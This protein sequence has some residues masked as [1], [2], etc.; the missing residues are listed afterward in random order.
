MTQKFPF[1]FF[2][3][4]KKCNENLILGNFFYFL[5][6]PAVAYGAVLGN[7][8]GIHTPTPSPSIN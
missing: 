3:S 8:L 4:G 6:I 1:S 5:A 2:N 7:Y